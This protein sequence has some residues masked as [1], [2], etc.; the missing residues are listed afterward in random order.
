MI[1]FIGAHIVTGYSSYSFEIDMVFRAFWHLNT[2]AASHLIAAVSNN[3]HNHFITICFQLVTALKC[4]RFGCFHSCSRVHYIIVH[5]DSRVRSLTSLE[6]IYTQMQ[7][8]TQTHIHSIRMLNVWAVST[9]NRWA[10][11]QSKWVRNLIFFS[12]F[13]FT[14]MLNHAN[15]HISNAST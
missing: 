6:Y 11:M 7:T 13:L 4:I 12:L 10:N 14:V 5:I 15:T 2:L 1:E 8:Q 9:L 3:C